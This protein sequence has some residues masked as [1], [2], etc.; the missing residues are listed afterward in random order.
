MSVICRP[1]LYLWLGLLVCLQVS[2]TCVC[3]CHLCVIVTVT[4]TLDVPRGSLSQGRGRSA[5][6]ARGHHGHAL[7]QRPGGADQLGHR[8]CHLSGID[9]TGSHW[10]HLWSRCRA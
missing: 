10:G 9:A 4:V 3:H 5:V 8:E 6:A 1:G 7:L 2:V